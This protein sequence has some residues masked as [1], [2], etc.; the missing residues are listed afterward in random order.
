[1]TAPTSYQQLR[2]EDDD[3]PRG[4]KLPPALIEAIHDDPAE[5]T[6]LARVY[7]AHVLHEMFKESVTY[8]PSQKRD[9]LDLC[10]RLGDL[11]PKKR[12]DDQAQTGGVVISINIPQ[13]GAAQPSTLTIDQPPAISAAAPTICIP[14]STAHPEFEV[15]DE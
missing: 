14:V 6:P 5:M 12:A 11:D 7:A 10:T 2:P 13:L 15:V 4:K 8:T 1:M 9:F 3:A